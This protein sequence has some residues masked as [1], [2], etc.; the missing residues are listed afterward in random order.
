MFILLKQG[1]LFGL[2][3]ISSHCVALAQTPAPDKFIAV[4]K[5]PK[6]DL[7]QLAKRVIYPELALRG[8]LEGKVVVR[9]LIDQN[10]IP[11]KTMIDYSNN[12]I[13]DSS[14]INAVMAT[15]YTPA[16]AQGKAISCWISI[17]VSFKLHG[18]EPLLNTNTT[19]EPKKETPIPEPK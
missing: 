2:L 13:F 4:E 8:G 16:I 5:E 18:S 12:R 14:A 7:Q 19:T 11:Q 17:P 10:G 9:V 3:Y 1:F 15:T 6:V